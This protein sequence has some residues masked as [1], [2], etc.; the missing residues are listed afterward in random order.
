MRTLIAILAVA[1]AVLHLARPELGIDAVFLGLLAFALFIYLFDIDAIEW[2]GIRARRRQLERKAGEVKALDVSTEEIPPTP[3]PPA[4]PT[5]P[6]GSQQDVVHRRANDL[7][8]PVDPSE[9]LFWV[10]EQIRIELVV[11]AGNSG[12]LVRQRGFDSYQALPLAQSLAQSGIIP[13][14][15]IDAIR[16][17]VQQRNALAHGPFGWRVIGDAAGQLGLEVLVKLRSIKRGYVRV[18]VSP[19]NLYKDHSLS[20]LHNVRGV[21]LEQIGLQGE[22]HQ[23]VYPT[24][25]VYA[26]G[27]FVTWEWDSHSGVDAEAWYEDPRAQQPKRAFSTSALFAGREYPD[28]WGLEFSVPGPFR[29]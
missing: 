3:A 14:E 25:F 22:S 1:V 17:V 11:L 2:Q 23:A 5:S 28:Q 24:T 10:T 20:A 26:P 19:V 16:T 27:R 21:L 12:R 6:A 18:V 7:M 15:L 4:P 13:G 9:R 8:P 29:M